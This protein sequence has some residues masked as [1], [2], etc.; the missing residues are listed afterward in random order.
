MQRAQTHEGI[1]IKFT[2]VSAREDYLCM[3]P[4]AISLNIRY[5]TLLST[6]QWSGENKFADHL[7]HKLLSWF[8]LYSFLCCA[9]NVRVHYGVLYLFHFR[10]ICSQSI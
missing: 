7:Q 2:M 1:D 9:H 10:F 4:L 3:L 8:V 5:F 6:G